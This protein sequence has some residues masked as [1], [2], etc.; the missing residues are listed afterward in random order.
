MSAAPRYY[1]LFASN[2]S[3]NS[4]INEIPQVCTTKVFDKSYDVLGREISDSFALCT[5]E[6][7]SPKENYVLTDAGY[8]INFL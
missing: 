7:G 2:I 1:W 4:G 5:L 8:Y 3:K 6:Y